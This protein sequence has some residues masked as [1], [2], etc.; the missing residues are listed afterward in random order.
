[1]STY[2]ELRQEILL[3]L[4]LPPSMVGD[5]RSLVDLKMARVVETLCADYRP[6]K[7]L[8]STSAFLVTSATT[9][10]DLSSDLSVDLTSSG[11]YATPFTVTID[12]DRSGS[13][14]PEYMRYVDYKAWIHGVTTSFGN[15]RERGTFT[16]TPSQE[17]VLNRWPTSS[18]EQWD[19]Y[20]WYFAKPAAVADAGVPEIPSYYHNAIISGVVREFPQYFIGD[21]EM[22]F[23]KFEKDYERARS[24][25][26]RS[27]LS[28]KGSLRFRAQLVPTGRMGSSLWPE[29]PTL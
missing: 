2:S 22:L 8:R 27:R 20:F 26:L 24:K 28:S 23:A 14:K 17:I 16:I 18:S 1:M 3:T 11:D 21:R 25:L 7:L 12:R 29:D 19:L 13:R 9:S 10:I 5:A 6:D 4:R 15:E